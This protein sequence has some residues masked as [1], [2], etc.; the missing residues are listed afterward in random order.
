MHRYAPVTLLLVLVASGASAYMLE[1]GLGTV[2]VERVYFS[3]GGHTSAGSL[4]TP[5]TADGGLPGV[6]LAHGISTSR[7]VMSGMALEMARGGVAALTIDLDGHGASGGS[8]GGGDPS[9]G[10]L[11][12]M[13]Y[14]KAHRL[15]DGGRLG[16]VGHSLGAGAARY[17]ALASGDVMAVVF[18][19]GGLSGEWGGYGSLNATFPPNLLIAVGRHDVLFGEG[20]TDALKPVFN[21]SKVEPRVTYGD[22]GA[23]TARRLVTP[24]TIHLLEPVHPVIVNEAL[25]WLTDTLGTSGASGAL[26]VWRELALAAFFASFHGLV[27]CGFGRV[28]ASQLQHGA[29]KLGDCMF[30]LLGA[31]LF[32]PSTL[33]GAFVPF[34]PMVFGASMAWWLLL[35]GVSSLALTV[36]RGTRDVGHH[37]SSGFSLRDLGLGALVFAGMYLAVA[38]FEA[39]TGLQFRLLVPIFRRLTL[40][41]AKLVPAFIPFY[42]AFFVSE[43]AYF[44]GRGDLPGLLLSKVGPFLAYLL[45]Q[46]GA[47]YLVGAR[48]VT[49]FPAFLGEFLWMVVPLLCLSTAYTWKLRSLGRPWLAV[50]LN[51]L[52]F[53]WVSAGL[54]PL[55]GL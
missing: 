37:I 7:E 43:N 6:V 25:R 27:L 50:V 51:T 54:F 9:L 46:Y 24:D 30:G 5:S 22:R 44:R 14:L 19:G 17:A 13:E 1:T 20:L 48:L 28:Y 18:I 40:R 2:K 55:G 47:M 49:G 11:A 39:L 29:L 8:L 21:A 16:L 33:V 38:L 23:G 34:P 31:I 53:S 45:V 32:P 36:I 52:M 26:Y 41:R 3:S 4:Y 35:W 10:V 15:V 42:A 12:A